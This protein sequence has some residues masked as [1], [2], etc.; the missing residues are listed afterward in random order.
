ML[1]EINQ[2]QKE[3]VYLYL[4]S[5]NVEGCG[6]SQVVECLPRKQQALSSNPNTTSKRE[7][8]VGL[9]SGYQG[10]GPGGVGIENDQRTQFQIERINKFSR[11]ILQNGDYS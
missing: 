4:E 11:S 3:D 8:K 6:V 1:S 9:S 10:L 5:K 2:T 7:K